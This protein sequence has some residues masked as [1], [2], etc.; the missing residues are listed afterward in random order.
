MVRT[1][2]KP[3]VTICVLPLVMKLTPKGVP[4][5]IPSNKVPKRLLNALKLG[6]AMSCQTFV[7]SEGKTSIAAAS[8]GAM[9]RPKNPMATV[10]SPIPST[11][12]TTPAATKIAPVRASTTRLSCMR[13]TLNQVWSGLE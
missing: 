11:P 2:P 1:T 12:L 3:A 7:M 10:G 9:T 4:K 6:P 8:T 13:R 5:Q